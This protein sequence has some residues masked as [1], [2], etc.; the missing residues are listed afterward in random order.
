MQ[1]QKMHTERAKMLS[2][3]DKCNQMSPGKIENEH[4]FRAKKSTAP[5]GLSES[6]QK[7][8]WPRYLRIYCMDTHMIWS[9][10]GPPLT[11]F[12]VANE[13]T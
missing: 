3:A 5:R 9:G 13:L 2:H 6:P 8:L 11:I 12:L 4:A 10:T 7:E 1:N